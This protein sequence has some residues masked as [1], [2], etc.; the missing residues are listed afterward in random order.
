MIQKLKNKNEKNYKDSNFLHDKIFVTNK[1]KLVTVEK[2]F[3]WFSFSEKKFFKEH[4]IYSSLDSSHFGIL[5][6]S[7]K[8]S[9]ILVQHIKN[10]LPPLLN[11]I[12]IIHSKVNANY[13][14]LGTSIP[15]TIEGKT[16][17]VHSILLLD[18]V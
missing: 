12:N 18:W 17:L 9:E 13:L 10:N 2:F 14:K 3:T 6:V 1:S 7:N 5:N 4:P 16:G 15:S 8:L 11:D